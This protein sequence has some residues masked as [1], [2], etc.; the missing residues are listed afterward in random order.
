MNALTIVKA[1]PPAEAF[2]TWLETGR[3]LL[4]ERNDVEWKL[5]DWLADGRKRAEAK[6]PGFGDQA[7]FDFLGSQ[8]GIAPKELKSAVRVATAF[9]AHL[10][11]AS[12]TY[13]HHESVS[14]LPATDA[15]AVLKSAKAQH[16][17]DRQTRVEAVKR[18]TQLSQR[19]MLPED[20]WDHHHLM[21]MTRAWNRSTREARETF[22][23]L[24]EEANLGTID[25]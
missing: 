7:S 5:A 24:T 12:L 23:E 13:G 6:E 9:P 8:L 1:E 4:H 20:D 11:D 22:L 19:T 21:N 10:R 14:N 18:Q 25:A 3:E 2:G 16:W 15:L 17:D